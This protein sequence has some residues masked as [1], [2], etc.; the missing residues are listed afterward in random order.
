VEP[1]RFKK[2]FKVYKFLQKGFLMNVYTR[3]LLTATLI[4]SPAQIAN[5]DPVI[6]EPN[7]K[8]PINATD[9]LF[10][11]DVTYCFGKIDKIHPSTHIPG[12]VNVVARTVCST[13][14]VKVTVTLTRLNDGHSVRRSATARSIAT[15]NVAMPCT[16]RR[17]EPL[18][19][20][21]A[22]A[23]FTLDNGRTGEKIV[24]GNL[25]C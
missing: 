4:L 21:Q 19:R 12:T 5:A 9:K 7:N 24:K 23:I 3:M 2:A 13:H 8:V 14:M 20:Y 17:G 18:M 22:V 25:N 15:V 11:P 6:D 10:F 16:W 1:P